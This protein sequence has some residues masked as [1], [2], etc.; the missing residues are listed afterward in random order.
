MTKDI[1]VGDSIPSLRKDVG[2]YQPI[3]Y[4]NP[5]RPGV[6]KSCGIGRN[7]STWALHYGI[8]LSD[9]HRL[10]RRRP[11]RLKK[12]KVRFVSP[13]K[14]ED[15]ITIEG[16]VVGKEGNTLRCEMSV[17]NQEGVEVMINVASEVEL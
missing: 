10:V 2:K 3:F 8:C 12:L 13:V 17:K 6:W 5:Y 14:P 9:E 16:K 4:A 1:K 7:Y 15:T 11:S